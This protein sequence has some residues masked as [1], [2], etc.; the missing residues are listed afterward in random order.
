MIYGSWNIRCHRQVILG[1]ILTFQP[2]DN[3][4]NQIIQLKKWR[5]YHFT[6]LQ[7]ERGA[8]QTEFFVI[9]DRFLCFYSLPPMDPKK[10]KFFKNEKNTWWYYHFTSVYHKWQSHDVWFLRYGVQPTQFFVILDRFYTFT[11]LTTRKIKILKKWK[12]TPGDIIVLHRCTI[13]DNH[14]MYGS[15]D[16]GTWRTEFFVILDRFLP[17]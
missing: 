16:Y 1:H 13:N 12:K 8:W 3:S 15:W 11:P 17:P 6:H 9:L 7:R 5:Y 10:S 2:P 14:M 4:E